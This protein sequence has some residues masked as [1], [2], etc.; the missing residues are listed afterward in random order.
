MNRSRIEYCDH[1]FNM[2]TGCLH[3]C[4][5]CYAEKMV[6]RFCGDSR[7]NLARTGEY[8][9]V[10]LNDGREGYVLDKPMRNE[11]GEIIVYPFGFSPTLHR[12][13]AERLD[14]LK[15]GNNIFVGAMA[16]LFG[17]W[18]PDEWIQE[19]FEIC[20]EHPLNN[21]LFLTK[22]PIRYPELLKKGLLPMDENYWYGS[23]ITDEET[24]FFADPRFNTFVSIEPLLKPFQSRMPPGM[25]DGL[26]HIKWIIIGAETGRRKG[27]VVPEFDWIKNIVRR[28]D[29]A[30]VP[31]F[32]KN[33][34]ISIVGEQNMR[35]EYPEALKKRKLSPKMEEKLYD[36]C[37]C[38]GKKMKIR[39]MV[40]LQAQSLRNSSPKKYGYMCWECFE[41]HC[42]TLDVDIP[43]IP[44]PKNGEET[45]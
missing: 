13:R 45:V 16:D 9:P 20:E 27:K 28:A 31:V 1:T 3:G 29:T 32:M 14:V 24:P 43:D 36:I 44:N 34:L 11:K 2:V 6:K 15:R 37:N 4:D 22:N 8:H 40:T 7:A 33:S 19:V 23:T 5:Y 21:Y 39:K 26:S 30:G 18:V 12:Y 35:R 38:C 17:E 42:N 41:E 25:G 10:Q